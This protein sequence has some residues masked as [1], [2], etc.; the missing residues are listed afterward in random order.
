MKKYI[1]A[2]LERRIQ[3][4]QTDTWSQSELLTTLRLN[5]LKKR[6]FSCKDFGKEYKAMKNKGKKQCSLSD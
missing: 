2:S 6:F 4:F 5:P 1:M 3:K